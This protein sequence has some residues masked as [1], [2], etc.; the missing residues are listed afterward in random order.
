MSSPKPFAELPAGC[1]PHR[2]STTLKF[3]P[4]LDWLATLG[5]LTPRAI[6]GVEVVGDSTY[7]RT[8]STEGGAF[9]LL[10]VTAGAKD[11]LAVELATNAEV[12]ASGLTRALRR[13][14]DLDAD[15]VAIAR[16]FEKDKL[17]GP[18]AYKR[19]GIRIPGCW[20]PFE[21]TIR[22]NLGQQVSVP[23]ATRLTGRVVR[24][25]CQPLFEQVGIPGLTHSFPPPQALVGA[26]LAAP[27][28]LSR[29]RARS[30][31]GLAAAVASDPSL[32]A[33]QG[34]LDDVV[35][36]LVALPGIGPRTA[37]YVAM[38][39]LRKDDA[40]PES[41]LGLLRAATKPGRERLKPSELLRL[42]ERWR[43]LRGYAAM[44]LWLSATG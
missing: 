12:K 29:T 37:N 2:L 19:P 5:C 1:P 16:H 30:I 14:F 15:L 34:E 10:R 44:H 43:P 23:G 20:D 17:I 33:D 8:L 42:A 35:A 22:V 40:F 11:E 9:G 7:S 24:L 31:S 25:H 6:P 38:R 28:G 27:V 18:L 26:D 32:L 36:R 13:L 39:G 41:D 21:L 3:E 4:P